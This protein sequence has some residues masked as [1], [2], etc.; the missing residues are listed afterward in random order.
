[1][2]DTALGVW[3]KGLREARKLSLRELG[4]RSEVRSRLHSPA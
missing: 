3:L 2:P 1:M 4:Q